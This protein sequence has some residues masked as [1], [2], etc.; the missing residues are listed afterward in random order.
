MSYL[1]YLQNVIDTLDASS[2]RMTQNVDGAIWSSDVWKEITLDR[3]MY[4]VVFIIINI[5]QEQSVE[6]SQIAM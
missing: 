2:V 1:R 4:L 6:H 5:A 3:F